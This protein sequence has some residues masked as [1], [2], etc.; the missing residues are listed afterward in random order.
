MSII[1]G[2]FSVAPCQTLISR[3]CAPFPSLYG[4]AVPPSPTQMAPGGQWFFSSLND[5]SLLTS[6]AP[7]LANDADV[8]CTHTPHTHST[9]HS[10]HISLGM[11]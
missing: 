11:T 4:C 2:P 5:S 9:Q 3:L 1:Q 10:H 6:F 7:P 8:R